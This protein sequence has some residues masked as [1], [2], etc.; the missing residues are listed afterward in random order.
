MLLGE[1]GEAAADAAQRLG[2][3]LQHEITASTEAHKRALIAEILYVEAPRWSLV[4]LLLCRVV[5]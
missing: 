1:H 3:V 5:R 2:A 4:S